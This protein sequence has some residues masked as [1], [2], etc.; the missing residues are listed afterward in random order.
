MANVSVLPFGGAQSLEV[1]YGAGINL[2]SNMYTAGRM[3]AFT[4]NLLYPTVVKIVEGLAA[5]ERLWLTKQ[6]TLAA[7]TSLPEARRSIHSGR[8]ARSRS[9]VS[10]MEALSATPG[11]L[12]QVSQ[13]AFD[14]FD[15]NDTLDATARPTDRAEKG[16]NRVRTALANAFKAESGVLTVLQRTSGIP[17]EW[18]S[19]GKKVSDRLVC[20]PLAGSADAKEKLMGKFVAAPVRLVV[21]SKE[22]AKMITEC[23][24]K[25][26]LH[27]AAC[28]GANAS[29]GTGTMRPWGFDGHALEQLNNPV[30]SIDRIPHDIDDDVAVSEWMHA[31]IAAAA[32]D[33]TKITCYC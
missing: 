24:I 5:T 30:T 26:K 28:S 32:A 19:L 7:D 14:F 25:T 12:Y 18:E 22:T 20:T 15:V 21:V 13:I 2:I 23:T 31:F 3:E 6:S 29:D 16:N 1:A 8:A 10:A 11:E 4:R 17:A 27:V 9:K 33:D